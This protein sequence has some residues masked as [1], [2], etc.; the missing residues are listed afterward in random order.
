[1]KIPICQEVGAGQGQL[2]T[3]DYYFYA[4]LQKSGEGKLSLF[5]VGGKSLGLPILQTKPLYVSLK[6]IYYNSDYVV[7]YTCTCM[8][9]ICFNFLSLLFDQA[10]NYL[11]IKSLLDVL[12]RTVADMI[13]GKD[14]E[15]I[16]RRFHVTNPTHLNSDTPPSS[17]SPQLHPSTHHTQ[18][19]AGSMCSVDSS[20]ERE[21]HKE[22]FQRELE[23]R[24]TSV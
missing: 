5:T 18:P 8:L 15:E 21:D 23:N 7:R 11:D 6:M 2:P 22:E 17:P 13:K 4:I 19:D 16:R 12:C 14:P 1:M 9:V 10:A 3:V 24:E 20:K